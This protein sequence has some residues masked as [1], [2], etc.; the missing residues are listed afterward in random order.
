MSAVATA[1]NAV[2]DKQDDHSNIICQLQLKIADLMDRSR[3]NNIKIRDIP[4]SVKPNKLGPYLKKLFRKWIPD[5]T[6]QDLLIDRFHRIQKPTY[7]PAAALR[8]TLARL[9]YFH[10]K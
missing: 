9:H 7:L 5:L 4:E 10:I 2:V 3:W 8:D 1:Y 6:A